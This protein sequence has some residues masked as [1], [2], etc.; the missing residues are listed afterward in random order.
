MA[1]NIKIKKILRKIYNINYDNITLRDDDEF[2]LQSN[3]VSEFTQMLKKV[4]TDNGIIVTPSG[5]RSGLFYS[6]ENDGEL[7]SS[8]KLLPDLVTF[9]LN[10]FGLKKNYFY[11]IT[12]LARDTDANTVITDDRNITVI[13]DTRQIILSSDLKGYDKNQECVGYFRALSNEVNLNFTFGKI[14][15]KDII[16]D[17]VVLLEEE[18]FNETVEDE[19]TEEFAEGKEILS[20]YGIYSLVGQVP[21]EFKGKYINLT[22]YSGRGMEIY[23]NQYDHT[24]TLEKSNT[25][26]ITNDPFTNL[27]Y[28][29]EFNCNKLPNHK[30]YEYFT[31]IDVSTDISPNTLKQGYMTFGFFKNGE[32]VEYTDNSGRLY[33]SVYQYK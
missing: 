18:N 15:I 30:I 9:G 24:Y 27:S 17:E 10:L 6:I 29:V 25:E 1:T 7:Y 4:D 20:M 3:G 26:N 13:D 14:V 21:K 31:V 8:S 5:Y 33:V 22:R 16:I 32:P 11:R 19:I 2:I 28:R 23:Y 12:I